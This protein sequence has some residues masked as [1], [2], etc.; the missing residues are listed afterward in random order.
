MK[1]RNPVAAEFRDQKLRFS[2]A[3]EIRGCDPIRTSAYAVARLA[4]SDGRGE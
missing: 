3:V 4:Q 1:N 2:I